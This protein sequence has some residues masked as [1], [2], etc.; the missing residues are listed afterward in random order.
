ME[1]RW[2]WDIVAVA[3]GL[4]GSGSMWLRSREGDVKMDDGKQHSE[5][6]G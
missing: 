1:R 4:T 5:E 3:G 2:D 6:Q